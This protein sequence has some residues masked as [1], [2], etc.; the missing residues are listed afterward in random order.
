MKK[1]IV[2]AM[3]IGLCVSSVFALQLTQEEFDNI[4][5]LDAKIKERYPQF[6][7]FN[8]PKDDMQTIGV[9]EATIRKEIDKIDI[10]T[11]KQKESLKKNEEELIQNELREI[12]IQSLKGKGVNLTTVSE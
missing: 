8:G 6:K 9:S 10:P 5:I 12:A 1:I 4:G 2:L 7:G 3:F 11:E